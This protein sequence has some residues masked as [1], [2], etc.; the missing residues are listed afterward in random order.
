MAVDIE[1]GSEGITP[2]L[3]TKASRVPPV[4]VGTKEFIIEDIQDGNTQDGRPRWLVWLRIVNDPK[5]PNT[6]LPYSVLL[7]WISPITG[8]WDVSNG[9]LLVNLMKG[10]GKRWEGD[11][12]KEEV[13][14]QYK[15][16][17]V[18]AGGFMRVGQRPNRDDPEVLD[19]TV[20][21]VAAK[22]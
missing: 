14:E 10:T 4:E 17:L 7:P 6:R 15:E 2:E 1:I 18:G 13:R 21:I 3:L 20:N 16:V 19:N 22:R 12:R 9:F 11:L 5:Y 8:G